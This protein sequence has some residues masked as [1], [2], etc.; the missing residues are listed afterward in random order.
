MLPPL[1]HQRRRVIALETCKGEQTT[2]RCIP[3]G[4]SVI[5]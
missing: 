3:L 4:C 5:Q 1:R 2:V